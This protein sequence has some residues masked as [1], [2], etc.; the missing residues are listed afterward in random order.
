MKPLGAVAAIVG[1]LW[2]VLLT[3]ILFGLGWAALVFLI[4][5]L[6]LLVPFMIL[7]AFGVFPWLPALLLYGGAALYIFTPERY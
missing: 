4:P 3:Y 5:P 6:D 1:W 7:D 2:L